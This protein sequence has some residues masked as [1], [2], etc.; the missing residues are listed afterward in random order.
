MVAGAVKPDQVSD[1]PLGEADPDRTAIL[2]LGMHRSGTSAITRVMSILGAALPERLMPKAEGNP[3]GY[4]EPM[5]IVTLHERLLASAGTE[6][7][8]WGAFP[9]DW[10]RG[11][12]RDAYRDELL[13]AVRR[14]YGDEDLFLVKDPRLLRFVPLW[15]DLL[16]R[17]PARPVGV[18]PFRNP[19]EVALS[20]KRRDGF[21]QEHGFLLWLRHILDAELQ[22]RGMPRAFISYDRLL[23]QKRMAT[24]GLIERLPLEWPRKTAAAFDEIA[25]FLDGKL[26][27]NAAS[28]EDLALMAGIPDSVRAAFRAYEQLETDPYDRAAMRALDDV[29]AE[30][31]RT[32][33]VLADTFKALRRRF[34]AE[35]GA[36]DGLRKEVE[37]YARAD[38]ARAED[39]G[40]Q[41]DALRE[42][43]A[44]LRVQADGLREANARLAA[45]QDG[46]R[47]EIAGLHDGAAAMH[48]ELHDLRGGLDGLRAEL[49]AAREAARTADAERGRAIETLRAEVLRLRGEGLHAAHREAEARRARFWQRRREPDPEREALVALV[50]RSGLFDPDWY[51]GRYLAADGSGP[52]PIDH[53]L[54]VGRVRRFSPGPHFDAAWYAESN[55]DVAASGHDLLLHY[56]QHGREE[57]RPPVRP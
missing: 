33:G 48:A 39:Q 20:L 23:E 15:L 36:F 10:Y 9:Q 3:V 38:A 45:D 24:Y 31:D 6:W 19:I 16:A 7:S 50:L 53:Y 44:E 12:S 22:S 30:F 8:D 51:R 34:E 2:V 21:P 4:F 13:E 49:Q 40:R 14:D 25:H 55:P 52:D 54:D 29:R 56:L 27:R 35:H 32:T 42:V 18:L 1:M 5:A 41:A 26:R 17:L 11:A 28:R 47:A 57:G 37:A 46:L 43:A